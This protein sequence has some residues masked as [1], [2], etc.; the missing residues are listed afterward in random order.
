MCQSAG[1][2]LYNGDIRK[3]D[4]THLTQYTINIKNTLC[5]RLTGTYS[6][7]HF[8]PKKTTCTDRTLV[9]K[10]QT[11]SARIHLPVLER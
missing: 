8:V 3:R 10:A 2:P 5:Y 11:L 9:M 1:N 7:E 4:Y 6:Q